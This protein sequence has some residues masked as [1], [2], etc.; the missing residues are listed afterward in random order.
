MLQVLHSSMGVHARIC[1]LRH[2]SAAS[3]CSAR[4]TAA[5]TGQQQ[6]PA[7]KEARHR[8]A[9]S[10]LP[11]SYLRKGRAREACELASVVEFA[12]ER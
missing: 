10:M 4:S 9:R 1:V 6:L 2:V 11:S 8:S 12:G 3:N 5:C 7:I